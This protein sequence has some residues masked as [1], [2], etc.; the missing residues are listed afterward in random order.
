MKKNLIILLVFLFS[1]SLL[2]DDKMNLGLEVLIIKRNV[3]HVMH[4]KHQ[5]QME[6]LDQT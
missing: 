6:K 2:A 1:T 3:E 4:L 5:D